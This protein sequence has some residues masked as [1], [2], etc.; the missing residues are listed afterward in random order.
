METEFEE[1]QFADFSWPESLLQP[2]VVS[3][4]LPDGSKKPIGSIELD[5]SKGEVPATYLSYDANGKELFPR[6]KDYEKAKMRFEKYAKRLSLAERT[7]K[8]K[9][10]R[11]R[12]RGKEKSIK[13]E[14]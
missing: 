2:L 11:Q 6:T 13:R 10:I 7:K 4:I 9:N 12:K 5:F 1:T 14:I 3:L 8:V